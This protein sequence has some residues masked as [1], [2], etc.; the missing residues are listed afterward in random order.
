MINRVL[1]VGLILLAAYGLFYRFPRLLWPTNP[2]W[3][4]DTYAENFAG[5]TPKINR[6]LEA[7]PLTN[8][9]VSMKMIHSHTPFFQHGSWGSGFVFTDPDLS[10]EIIFARELENRAG[11][12][13]EAYPGRDH[14]LYFGTLNKG[15]IIPRRMAAN[16]VFY[17]TPIRSSGGGRKGIQLLSDPLDLYTL[18]SQEFQYFLEELYQHNDLLLIDTSYL[19]RSGHRF[20]DT[21]NYRRAAFFYEAALQMEQNPDNRYKALNNLSQCYMNLEKG[22]DAK[23]IFT[24]LKDRDKPRLFHLFPE[25]GF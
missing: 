5:V 13:I 22:E 3:F 12:L 19:I 9:V 15:F 10:G 20:K 7:L 23:K 16:R 24:A 14:Y 18:Y 2:Q 6:T 25:R 1:I 21:G 17:G 11:D 4:Y 8:A